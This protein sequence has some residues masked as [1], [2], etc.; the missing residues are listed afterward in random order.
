[1]AETELQK[2]SARMAVLVAA[3]GYFVDA[4]DLLLFN[5]VRIS[6]LKDLGVPDSELLSVGVD[7]LNLQ[8]GGMLI[9]GIV[10]GICGDRS[11]R[12]SVLF[13]SILLYS[14]ANIANAF[15]TSI[16]WYGAL[17]FIA[18]LGLAGELGAGITLVSEILD[19]EHRGIGTSI[20]AAVGVAGVV[21][22]A[23]VGDIFPWRTAY[24]IGGIMGLLL[25]VLRIS[26]RESQMFSTMADGVR[27]AD[28]RLFFQRKER[29]VRY[30]S[31]ILMGV[32][33]W[34]A[35]GILVTFCPEIGQALGMP[36]S[37]TAVR[38][39]MFSYIGLVFGDL[40]SGLLSQS[41]KSRK[42]VVLLFMFGTA[43]SCAGILLTRG[44]SPTGFYALCVPL[45]FFAGYW[46]VFV[47]SAAEQFGT[48][49]R[50]TVTTTVP[51][52]VRGAVVPM[53][54]CFKALKPETGVLGS[55]AI[56]GAA[57][58]VIGLLAALNLRETFGRDLDFVEE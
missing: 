34:Y 14:V 30:L 44:L 7:L 27:R 43:V 3:L 11:G 45:G 41:L 6:S 42:K 17:R 33:I 32:P 4:Y 37:P 29:L 5:I 53:T 15:V 21:V 57:C 55:A 8:M 9:G 35:I 26:V 1:M 22:A 13:G 23:L 50:A 40:A 39:V 38:A 46:A 52:F 2:R 54:T 10:W 28:L 36:V 24:A 19:R 51:N 31:C 49:L 18:G 20:V 47:T 48:N 12:L 25:L 58:F 16:P 56:V